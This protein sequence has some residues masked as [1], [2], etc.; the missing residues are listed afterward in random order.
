MAQ[1]AIDAANI[2]EHLMKRP[3]A[4]IL[5]QCVEK[6]DFKALQFMCIVDYY[7]EKRN[8]YS[9]IGGSSCPKLLSLLFQ[10]RHFE[11]FK[12]FDYPINRKMKWYVL[13]CKFCE[14]TG[15]YRCILTH[16]AI[17]H[18]VHIGLKMCAYCNKKEL[19]EHFADNSLEQCY[20]EYFQRHHIVID[21]KM[22]EIVADFYDMMKQLSRKLKIVTHRY[23]GFFAHAYGAVERLDQSYGE[24]FPNELTVFRLKT[25]SQNQ[26]IGSTKLNEEFKQV[27][28]IL[29]GGT[30]ATNSIR[31]SRTVI[32]GVM[33]SDS[34]DDNRNESTSDLM[35][36]TQSGQSSGENEAQ[37]SVSVYIETKIAL[38]IFFVQPHFYGILTF[39]FQPY[40]PERLDA[41]NP[42]NF[43]NAMKPETSESIQS[44]LSVSSSSIP[45]NTAPSIIDRS[46]TQSTV[47]AFRT[48]S[49]SDRGGWSDKD[50]TEQFGLYV[51]QRIYKLPDAAKR[52][53]LETSIQEAIV[54]AEKEAFE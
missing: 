5:E 54:K 9:R 8:L 36:P 28:N 52:R 15:P 18:N 4:A 39:I 11:K 20:N 2:T 30:K 12:Y 22:W 19:K 14:L 31:M 41:V 45:T 40:T 29:F 1:S 17:N 6:D 50:E 49:K 48:A 42:I 24:D 10:F 46:P 16:M 47:N 27:A 43:S 44:A 34:D 33:V 26:S 35:Q 7:A 37:G 53:K 3:I 13:Q 21:E 38:S 51:A 32:S 23:S 25:R